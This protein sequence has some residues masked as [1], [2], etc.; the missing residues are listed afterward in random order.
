MKT[1]R[2]DDEKMMD[3]EWRESSYGGKES[4]VIGDN[5]ANFQWC[6]RRVVPFLPPQ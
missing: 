5:V 6:A 1:R 4:A 2:E 3:G